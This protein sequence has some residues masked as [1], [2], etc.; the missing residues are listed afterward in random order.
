VR[1]LL[2]LAVLA[3]FAGAVNQAPLLA[4]EKP[5][6]L[7]TVAYDVRDLLHKPELFELGGSPWN[8]F[9]ENLRRRRDDPATNAGRLVQAIVRYVEVR[10]TASSDE[11]IT[12]VNGSRLMVRTTRAKHAEVKSLLDAFR[13][14]GDLWVVAK[15]ELYEVDDAFYG[16]LKAAKRLSRQDLEESE[17]KFLA[18]VPQPRD[19]LFETLTKQKP[20]LAGDE[21]KVDSGFEATL[22]SRHQAITC[23]PNRAQIYKGDKSPQAVLTGVSF[24][25]GMHIS[26]DRRYVRIR[27][28]EKAVDLQQIDRMKVTE[29]K[30]GNDVNVETPLLKET[31]HT[32]VLNIPDG[33]TILVAVHERPPALLDKSRWWVLS[34][35]PR[36]YIE[37]EEKLLREQQMK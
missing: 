6:Q 36:I 16:K 26:S 30:A 11:A 1:T 13:R 28:T 12:I 27:L 17:T 10:P 22:L 18:G 34:I 15:A 4:Q 7:E 37:E 14:L 23:L 24:L 21:I 25:G 33:G 32:Q 5:A 35:T 8:A 29:D 9:E 31:T 2:F 19:P 3:S 20:V